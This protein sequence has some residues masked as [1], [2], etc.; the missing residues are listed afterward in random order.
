[1]RYRSGSR[2]R[3]QATLRSQH[4]RT[5]RRTRRRSRRGREPWSDSADVSLDLFTTA[6]EDI[7]AAAYYELIRNWTIGTQLAERTNRSFS[8]IN[9]VRHRLEQAAPGF[10]K[11]F[12]RTPTRRFAHLTSG[13]LLDD[14][15]ATAELPAWFQQFI[16]ER[17][18]DTRWA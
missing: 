2:T 10:E 9:L 7:A 4:A 5:D 18:L 3:S 11:A 16:H 17:Q 8:L 13:A 14:L 12:A 1:V 15:S 6:A